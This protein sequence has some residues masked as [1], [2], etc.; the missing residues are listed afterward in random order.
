MGADGRVIFK[1]LPV[2]QWHTLIPDAHEGYISWEEYERNRRW[3]QR[4]SQAPDGKRGYPPREGPAL[5][6]GLAVCGLCGRQMTVRYR[7]RRGSISPDY[8]CEGMGNTTALPTCQSIPGQKIDD[9][10]GQL[11]LEVV[12]PVALEVCLQVQEDLQKRFEEADRLRLEQVERA[13]Y[14]ADLARHRYMKVDP[15][16]R[17]VADELEAEWNGRL[18]ALREAEQEY[19]AQRESDHLIIDEEKRQRILSLA[20]SFPDLWRNPKT[21]QRERKRMVQLLIED[22]TLVKNDAV[23]V[24]VRFKGGA[25]RSLALP[26]ALASWQAW[27]IGKEV[28][29]EI[30]RLLDDQTYSETAAILNERGFSSGQGRQ[31]D[32]RRINVIRRAYGLKDRYTRLHQRGFLSLKEVAAKLGLHKGTVKRKRAMDLLGIGSRKLNDM[33]EYMYED[34]DIPKARCMNHMLT[35]PKEVQYEA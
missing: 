24:N 19:R 34:P 17:L 3:L 20:K 30:D 14:E 29:A 13:R 31:F 28:V 23:S 11:L 16:N 35:C 9:A 25:T 21:P 15:D 5:L 27:M 6:Q 2:E 32:G 22:V 1:E 10:I 26:R 33:G 18:R 7:K 8:I 12:T 4:N